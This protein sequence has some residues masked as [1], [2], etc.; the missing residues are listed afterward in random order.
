MIIDILNSNE[1]IAGCN[2]RHA[3]DTMIKENGKETYPLFNGNEVTFHT[4]DKKNINADISQIN[5][6][7]DLLIIIS[8]HSSTNPIPVLTVHSPGNYGIAQLG[9]NNH[10]LAKCAPAWMKSV[11]QNE[12]K[13]VPEGYQVSFEITH[14]GPTD[15]PM[16]SFFVEVG[17]TST[18]W[19]DEKAY[20]AVAK[21]VLYA[22]PEKEIIPLIGFGGTHYAARQTSIALET[23]GAFG[24]IMHSRN[25]KDATEEMVKQ[26]IEKSGGITAAYIDY[27][28][29][30]KE[31]SAHIKSILRE[32]DIPDLTEQD[33][34]NL[35]HFSFNCWNIYESYVKSLDSTL[36]IHPH[37][38]IPEGTP[39]QINIPDNLFS[40]AFRKDN[41]KLMQWLDETGGIVHLTNQNGNVIPIFLTDEKNAKRLSVGLIGITIQY[42]TH[43]LETM[44]DGDK[45][46]VIHRQFDPSL[47]RKL[48]VPSGPLFGK[49]AS[50]TA[51]TLPDGT[52]IQPES[53]TAI[54]KTTIIIPNMEN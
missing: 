16:P 17:S 37:G 30:P 7:A 45:L 34:K 1:D 13:F 8:R 31:E 2:I 44:I 19:N 22:N 33:L 9:G 5:R 54:H 6:N 12:A 49:L 25:I 46:T 32:L 20:T 50:G 24:H 23:K 47:A 48:G 39:T 3:I 28:S 10:E 11:L 26:M 38:F 51:I 53:V 35:N 43:T 27:K 42:I 4:T 41:H 52:T 15:F 18:E 36:K 14:H 21:S 40:L 29:M